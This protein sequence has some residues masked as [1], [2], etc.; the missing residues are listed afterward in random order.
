[1]SEE[2][3]VIELERDYTGTKHIPI[4]VMLPVSNSWCITSAIL[5]DGAF[6]LFILFFFTDED[7]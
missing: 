2:Q 5:E 6:F 3:D 7:N 4:F 1:M